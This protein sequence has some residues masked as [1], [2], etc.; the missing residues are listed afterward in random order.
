[1][2]NVPDLLRSAEYAGFK[3]SAERLGYRVEG[4][5]LNTADYGAATNDGRGSLELN[6]R[7]CPPLVLVR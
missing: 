4:R 1:M 5:I 2:E 7:P 3:R 6:E